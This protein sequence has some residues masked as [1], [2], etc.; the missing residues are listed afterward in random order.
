[1]NENIDEYSVFNITIS[2]MIGGFNQSER[3]KEEPLFVDFNVCLS[4]YSY[5]HSTIDNNLYFLFHK[6]FVYIII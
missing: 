1:M 2:N 6:T 3:T 4:I 5:N